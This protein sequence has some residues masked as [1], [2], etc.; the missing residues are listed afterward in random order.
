MI[1]PIRIAFD[2]G[3]P[4]DHAFETWTARID[5]WWPADHTVTGRWAGR[6]HRR[7]RGPARWPHLR[8]RRRGGIEHEWGEVTIWEPP[9]RLGY[10]WHLRR[11]RAD[12]TDVEI[13]F[14]DRGD[15]STLVEIVHSAWERLG[16]EGET[17][18]DR[19][20]GGW[21]T[22]LPHFVEAA[23]GRRRLS[24]VDQ[25][26][27]EGDEHRVR[28]RRP[29]LERPRPERAVRQDD[30]R[31]VGEPGSTHRNVPDPPK[32]PNADGLL[33]S[34]IQCGRLPSWSSRPETPVARIEVADPRHHAGSPGKA[35]VDA[36]AAIAGGTRV[37][38]SE[39]A[40]ERRQVRERPSR[41][42]DGRS[43]RTVERHPERSEDPT[44]QELVESTPARSATSAPSASY[45]G[46]E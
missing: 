4:P 43:T 17:W 28:E 6:A 23:G 11:D 34:P 40:G 24:P 19:N 2:V 10:L 33:R 26:S 16:A 32:C 30:Q 31:Q 46:F 13:R 25:D 18:R 35:T 39:L 42:C 38:R 12:A 1:E 27:P 5:R 9:T 20:H 37:G 8:A 14:L 29:G 36:R 44:V 45:P 7:A 22:L 3:C 15:G 21:A 41:P